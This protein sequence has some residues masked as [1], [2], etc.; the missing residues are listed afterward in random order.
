MGLLLLAI[1]VFG[2]LVLFGQ[3]DSGRYYRFLIF[4]IIGP[5]LASIGISH[6]EWFWSSAS[7]LVKLVVIFTLPFLVAG[8]LRALL[9]KSRT[10]DVVLSG[11]FNGAV[12]LV[13]FPLRL[14]WRIGSYTFARERRSFPLDR[15]R[16][17][18][19]TRPPILDH[20]VRNGRRP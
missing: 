7:A 16:P 2:T 5:I 13:S 3:A 14:L 4:L 17:A 18:V 1:C 6:L 11:L 8:L 15:Y 19:G 9:P 20:R 10:V 12:A